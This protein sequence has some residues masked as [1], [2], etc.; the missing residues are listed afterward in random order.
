MQ[1]CTW[2]SRQIIVFDPALATHFNSLFCL[3]RKLSKPLST[4]AHSNSTT[5][6]ARQADWLSLPDID[7]IWSLI[8]ESLGSHAAARHA[9]RETCAQFLDAVRS[10]AKCL[11][12]K[13]PPSSPQS[14]TT[15]SLM[16][17]QSPRGFQ[18]PHG[19]T[20]LAVC[21]VDLLTKIGCFCC[22]PDWCVCM[23]TSTA[24][25]PL[26]YC[27]YWG[28]PCPQPGTQSSLCSWTLV[29]HTLNRHTSWPRDSYAMA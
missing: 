10:S 18:S 22:W 11:L 20:V 6:A 25:T 28:Q 19:T 8:I 26:Y 23:P 24:C 17:W 15:A 2:R 13:Y 3:N 4:R 1:L 29:K 9:L 7:P 21:T 12:F 14:P 16:T 5:A 27:F